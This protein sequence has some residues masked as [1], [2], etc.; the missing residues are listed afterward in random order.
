MSKDKEQAAEALQRVRARSARINL[1]MDA[2]PA[3][4]YMGGDEA[5]QKLLKAAATLDPARAKSTSQLVAE[6]AAAQRSVSAPS[7]GTSSKKRKAGSDASKERAAPQDAR[8]RLELRQKLERRIAE[9][10]EERRQKQS[11]ADKAKAA[12]ARSQ[13][14]NDGGKGQQA[15]QKSKGAAKA[16]ESSSGPETN[17]LVFDASAGDVPFAATVG[18]KGAKARKIHTQLKQAE[19]TER[20]IREAEAEGRGDDLRREIAMKNALARARGEKVHDNVGKLRKAQNTLD[21]K[22]VKSREAW[23]RRVDEEKKQLDDRQTQRQENLK[24]KRAGSK[25]AKARAAI[26]GRGFEGKHK[27]LLNKD[28]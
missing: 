28:S 24:A 1:L 15:Q 23:Q 2:I 21:K 14:G 27:G 19:A 20:Q 3:R 16:L 11:A 7:G 25:K 9:L 10:K 12:E 4:F 6:A 5:C 26:D 18:R 13:R 17:R 22:K 8:S